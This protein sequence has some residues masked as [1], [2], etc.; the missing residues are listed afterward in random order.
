MHLRLLTAPDPVVTLS[1]A[2]AH[3]RIYHDTDDDYIESLVEAATSNIDGA[4]GRLGRCISEQSW[5]MT[6]DEF[7]P[8]DAAGVVP[9]T[10]PLPPL[11]TIDEV[12]YDSDAGVATVMSS[13]DYRVIG[14]GSTNGAYIVPIP[15]TEWPSTHCEP[16]S[17]RVSFTAGFAVIPAS[18][19][20]AILLLVSHMNE[21]RE[22]NLDTGAKFGLI[23][24]P[25]GAR[26]LL[27]PYEFTH[28]SGRHARS[29]R[30][31]SAHYRY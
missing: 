24:L 13:D 5:E 21:H 22:E 23:E 27:A 18:I 9:L 4:F 7:P 17:V 11:I 26:S 30:H 29:R 20:Q 25:F 1:E 14:A 31:R 10:I 6:I 19:K 16:A 12:E 28:S 15:T 3:L 8:N 2:K